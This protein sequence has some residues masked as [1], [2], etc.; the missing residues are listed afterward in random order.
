M[1]LIPLNPLYITDNIE[2][3]YDIIFK[4]I[5]L[6]LMSLFSFSIIYF[7]QTNKQKYN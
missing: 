1:A 3:E 2:D 6:P 5:I 4:F 7:N